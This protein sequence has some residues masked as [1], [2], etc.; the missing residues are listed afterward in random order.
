M[1]PACTWV[2]KLGGAMLHA[3]ELP[4]WLAACAGPGRARPVIVP[5]GGALADCVRALQARW[6]FD[7]ALAHE[8]ALEAMRIN[9]RVLA[10]LEPALVPAAADPG[11]GCAVIWQPPRPWRAC[12]L[13]A[14]WDASADSIALALAVE[15]GAEAVLLVK[16]VPAAALA[17][18]SL[19]EL[20]AAGIVD[21]HIVALAR[22]AAPHVHAC[23][24]ADHAA[25][26][27]ARVRAVL[28]WPPLRA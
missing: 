14:S 25:F 19:S 11:P 28:P 5:G 21:P 8:L 23:T 13:P 26:A 22:T 4:A 24:R 9:A 1:P 20:A 7:D 16:S 3:P 12:P 17:R 10:A 18:A 2:V 27:A 6:S 15:L